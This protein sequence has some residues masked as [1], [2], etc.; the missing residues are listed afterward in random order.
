MYR[1]CIVDTG[2]II[3]WVR[4]ES[5]G[6]STYP[7]FFFI[8]FEFLHPINYSAVEKVH[9]YPTYF[10]NLLN[11]N[12]DISKW[13]DFKPFLKI[14]KVNVLKAIDI[15]RIITII[16]FEIIL[17]IIIFFFIYILNTTCIHFHH[18]LHTY[19][20]VYS[21]IHNSRYMHQIKFQIH[22]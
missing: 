19:V 10:I 21:D 11:I 15:H 1:D 9:S 8:K 14:L 16:H 20:W 13:I 3:D 4:Y 5:I 22:F 17:E 6:Y 2:S 18:T 7:F 12:V